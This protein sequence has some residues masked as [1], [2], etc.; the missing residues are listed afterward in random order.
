[1][2]GVFGIK[3]VKEKLEKRIV[4]SLSKYPITKAQVWV[5][6]YTPKFCLEECMYFPC[7]NEPCTN[8]DKNKRQI[9]NMLNVTS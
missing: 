5:N 4:E 7:N 8:N 1:M 2:I 3:H 9:E 6:N